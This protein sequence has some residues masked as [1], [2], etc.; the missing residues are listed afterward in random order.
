MKDGDYSE[1]IMC[2][3][4]VAATSA[5]KKKKEKTFNT[6]QACRIMSLVVR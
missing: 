6:W 3:P 4:S 1:W 5:K 2:L